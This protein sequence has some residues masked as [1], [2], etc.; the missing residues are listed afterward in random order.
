ME[1]SPAH[2][3]EGRWERR[4]DGAQ[5]RPVNVPKQMPGFL[6]PFLSG[7]GQRQVSVTHG[8]GL[9]PVLKAAECVH[10][11]WESASFGG[12]AFSFI[13]FSQSPLVSQWTLREIGERV[14]QV[15]LLSWAFSMRELALL[16][17]WILLGKTRRSDSGDVVESVPAHSGLLPWVWIAQP[18]CISLG[19]WCPA[20]PPPR[21]LLS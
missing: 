9:E 2:R 7:T 8:L 4:Q 21:R 18:S 1:I 11:T 6:E 16:S 12:D 10:G 5:P 20:P 3:Q 17:L 19:S 15:Q 13:T 14:G